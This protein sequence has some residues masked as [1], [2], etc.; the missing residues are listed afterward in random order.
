MAKWPTLREV[1]RRTF[2]EWGCRLP[3][4]TRNPLRARRGVGAEPAEAAAQREAELGRGP[5]S[6]SGHGRYPQLQALA[7]EK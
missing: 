4:A 5:L 2:R 6:K 1:F 7:T 3:G